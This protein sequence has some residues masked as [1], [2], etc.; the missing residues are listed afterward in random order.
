MLVDNFSPVI[1]GQ[2]S[3]MANV[4][5]AVALA[6]SITD[7]NDD[8]IKVSTNLDTTI[9]TNVGDLYLFEFTMPDTTAFTFTIIAEVCIFK[10]SFNP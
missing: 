5:E 4:G 10:L 8:E 1:S 6:F 9:I 7:P 2:S 3:T